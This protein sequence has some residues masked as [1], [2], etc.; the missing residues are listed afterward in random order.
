MIIFSGCVN[1]PKILIVGD[2]IS[3]GY[4]PFVESYFADKATV[5]HNPG[6]AQHTGTGL[7]NIRDWVGNEKWDI[8]QI[9]WGLWDIAHN[10]VKGRDKENGKITFNIDEYESNLDSIVSII[11]GMTDATIIFVTT[12][13]VPENEPGRYTSAVL[14]FNNAAIKVI[15]NHEILVN[16][17]YNESILIH[18]KYGEGENDVHYTKEGYVELS[19]LIIDF[20][21]SV[22]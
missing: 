14:K 17:I 19:K 18:N 15:T 10:S 13:Y 2:S 8:I 12:T 3:I 11:K 4:T 22:L 6:N 21:E 7:A 20:I 16:D 9:N 1:K 5:I